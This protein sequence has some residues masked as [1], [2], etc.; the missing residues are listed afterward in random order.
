MTGGPNPDTNDIRRM[1]ELGLSIN[2]D[3]YVG[4]NHFK[5]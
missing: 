3:L 2:F 4:G 5:E 1:N